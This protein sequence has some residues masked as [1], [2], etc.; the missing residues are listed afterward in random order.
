M[1]FR[2]LALA[3]ACLWLC[4]CD[5]GTAGVAG[6]SENPTQSPS[7][8]PSSTVEKT[9]PASDAVPV[10]TYRV[11]PRTVEDAISSTGEL[12][13]NE[14][15]DLRAEE[16]GRVVALHFE[17]GQRV[18]SGDLL[19]KTNDADLLAERRRL[20]VQRELAQ[21][22]EDRTKALLDE[23]TLSQ[24]AYEEARGRRL[25]LEAEIEQ[26]EAKL[27]KTEIRAP[28]AGTVGLRHVSE[29]SYITSSTAIARLQS[30]D[31][32]K[33]DF[34][35]P[36]K[37]A[38]EIGRG[39]TVSF[40]VSGIDRVFEGKVYAVEPRID[41]ATRTLQV[42]ARAAN[43]DGRLFPGAFAKVRLVLD[44]QADAMLIP[45]IALI[46]GAA[47]TKV[48]V[49]QEGRAEPRAVTVGRRTEDRVQV[50]SGLQPGDQVVVS[51]IQ[52]M[53]PGLE[54]NAREQGQAP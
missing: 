38:G 43:G 27:A 3:F 19:V 36:E 49:V 15:V 18:R 25:V 39:A 7:D 44:E 13:A 42:R 48:Y 5:S 22:R 14:E 31:P 40:T 50:L 24:E 30:L 8:R 9:T 28:F 51:G 20:Q 2:L 16:G 21:R 37:Y 12:R 10:Q 52:Q 54:V 17:E 1:C 53:R 26:V 47:G 32:I 11:R 41:A 29:G 45:S 4:A 23:Q 34:A 6:A 46:P 33:L 35:V